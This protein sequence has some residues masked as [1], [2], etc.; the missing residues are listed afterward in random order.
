MAY[1]YQIVN[2][3]NEKVYVGKTEFSIQKRF[4]EHCSDAL[5]EKNKKQTTI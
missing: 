5:R 3:V 4:K 1:I 2:D